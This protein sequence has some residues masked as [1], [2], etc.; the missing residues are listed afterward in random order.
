VTTIYLVSS[1]SISVLHKDP[2]NYSHQ[3]VRLND[4]AHLG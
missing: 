4:A 2:G 1:G 3:P